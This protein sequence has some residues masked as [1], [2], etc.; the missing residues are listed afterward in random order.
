MPFY[1]VP[2]DESTGTID[3]YCTPHCG[4]GM[5]GTIG[6]TGT[7]PCVGDINGDGAV[8]V[9]DLLE[10]LA[11]FGDTCSGCGEDL[12]GDG[13]VGVDDLLALLAVYGSDC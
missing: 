1:V 3:Y 12:N 10:L 13:A 7:G 11:V 8:G 5:V 9:D 6:V 2:T 4:S